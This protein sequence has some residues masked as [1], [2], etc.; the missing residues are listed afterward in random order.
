MLWLTQSCQA[1]TFCPD[2]LARAAA[3]FVSRDVAKR[4]RL[5]RLPKRCAEN[6]T[7][8]SNSADHIVYAYKIARRTV[9]PRNMFR[10]VILESDVVNRQLSG[11]DTG[12]DGDTQGAAFIG[13]GGELGSRSKSGAA[14]A[15]V[16]E[17]NLGKRPLEKSGKAPGS[18]AR[19][20]PEPG[21]QP[22]DEIDV[23][24]AA[25]SRKEN[26]CNHALSRRAGGSFPVCCNFQKSWRAQGNDHGSPQ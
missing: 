11:R 1:P 7:F 3:V 12:L 9:A 16:V 20:A 21:N 8:P 24:V 17:R 18:S 2:P 23:W 13:K 15:T 6:R 5:G 25:G 4:P 14:P 26:H 10:V 22:C 19:T